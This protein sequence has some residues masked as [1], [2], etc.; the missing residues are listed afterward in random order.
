MKENYQE[1]AQD[2]DRTSKQRKN[3]NKIAPMDTE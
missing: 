2:S 3:K 1:V